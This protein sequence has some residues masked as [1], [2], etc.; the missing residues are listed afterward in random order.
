MGPNSSLPQHQR[1]QIE[2]DNKRVQGKIQ[3]KRDYKDRRNV[4][5][6]FEC[7]LNRKCV[8]D[9]I[10]KQFNGMIPELIKG[11]AESMA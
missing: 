6:R 2:P 1:Y 10:L 5:H 8:N 7:N 3:R 11:V 9:Q 4:S